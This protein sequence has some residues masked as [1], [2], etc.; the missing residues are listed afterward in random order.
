MNPE[1][2]SALD[3]ICR[4]ALGLGLDQC[5]P[6][7]IDAATVVEA[8]FPMVQSL[9]PR[10]TEGALALDDAAEGVIAANLRVAC[11]SGDFA[12]LE[13]LKPAARDELRMYLVMA[14]TAIQLMAEQ[15]IDYG[16][17]PTGLRD[18]DLGLA[19][20]ALEILQARSPQRLIA[21]QRRTAH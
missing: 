7:M 16:P 3:A 20:L 9:G 15:G 2:K 12:P 19:A 14:I 10:E 17:V 21:R 4:R 8:L 6:A 13:I 11:K 1:T 5:P 18:R